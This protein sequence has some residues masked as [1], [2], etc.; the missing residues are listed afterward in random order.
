MTKK[1]EVKLEDK[2]KEIIFL[3]YC[4]ASETN[5]KYGAERATQKILQLSPF[6]E[7]EAVR[8]Y[9]ENKI[10]SVN[11]QVKKI[12]LDLRLK[13]DSTS[14]Y[15][16]IEEIEKDLPLLNHILSL[17]SEPEEFDLKDYLFTN[18]FEDYVTEFEETV[19]RKF[20]NG[21]ELSFNFDT[22]PEKGEPKYDLIIYWNE[23]N[24]YK[25]KIPTSKSFFLQLLDALRIKIK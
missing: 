9:C 24:I 18:D 16:Q 22:V 12:K 20:I 14:S 13:L 5:E 19:Y 3:D 11:E 8:K 1:E 4:N 6:R 15:R 25:G 7:M 2:I 17:L 21:K 23:D 10:K